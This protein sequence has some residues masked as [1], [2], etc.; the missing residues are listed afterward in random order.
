MQ[1]TDFLSPENLSAFPSPGVG[2]ATSGRDPQSSYKFAFGGSGL[3]RLPL[4][5][6]ISTCSRLSF[7]GVNTG[8]GWFG[9]PDLAPCRTRSAFSH[10]T[11]VRFLIL[12]S[13]E[14]KFTGP[15]SSYGRHA[16]AAQT[17]TS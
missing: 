17:P 16:P 4:R 8:F 12:S 6:L 13:S 15:D 2:T 1:E 14:L 10:P 3:R 9:S 5:P 7:P 11:I